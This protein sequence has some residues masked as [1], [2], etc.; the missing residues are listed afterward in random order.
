MG[1]DLSSLCVCVC[2]PE[3]LISKFK[4]N[5][6]SGWPG[7]HYV[8]EVKYQDYRCVYITCSDFGSTHFLNQLHSCKGA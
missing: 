1:I 5:K 2:V 4:I 6:V 8:K 7:T 3:N